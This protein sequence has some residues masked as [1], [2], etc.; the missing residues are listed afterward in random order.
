MKSPEEQEEDRRKYQQAKFKTKTI[1]GLNSKPSS[2]GQSGGQGSQGQSAQK[3]T[4]QQ[5]QQTGKIDPNATLKKPDD[6]TSTSSN[7]SSNSKP[8]PSTNLFGIGAVKKQTVPSQPPPN[9]QFPTNQNNTTTN[10][11]PNFSP[12]S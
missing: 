2:G 6:Q 9:P 4:Q 3:V 12:N 1:S 7:S 5:P 11:N 10:K 8:S